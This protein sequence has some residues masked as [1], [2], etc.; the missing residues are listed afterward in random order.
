[1]AE[2]LRFDGDDLGCCEPGFFSHLWVG[3]MEEG[4]D[5]RPGLRVVGG[6]E[7]SGDGT[8]EYTTADDTTI[9]LNYSVQ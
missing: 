7:E 2:A 9:V 6:A 4:I 3:V 8:L 5:Q 1:M